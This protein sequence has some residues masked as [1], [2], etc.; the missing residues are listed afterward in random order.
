[1]RLITAH[2]ILIGAAIV[3]ALL[4]T[5]VQVRA[6]V[7][8]GSAGRLAMGLLSL[9][10]AVALTVYYRSLAGWGRR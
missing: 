5:L 9:G 3:F 4:F 2:R 10:A 6:Y 8:D 1:V 7:G